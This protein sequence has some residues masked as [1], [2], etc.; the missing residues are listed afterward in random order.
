MDKGT[1]QGRSRELIPVLDRNPARNWV[2][3]IITQVGW[4]FWIQI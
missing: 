1:G 3:E 2:M 4:N